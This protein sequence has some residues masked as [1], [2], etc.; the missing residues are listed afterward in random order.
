MLKPFLNLIILY[1]S[2]FKFKLVS[3]K[4]KNLYHFKTTKAK[5]KHIKVI[6][7][8]KFLLQHSIKVFLILIN[9]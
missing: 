1:M 7:M 5:I 6:V 8:K 9:I 4:C 2:F 3:I